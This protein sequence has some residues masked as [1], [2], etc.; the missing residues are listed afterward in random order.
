MKELCIYYDEC[1]KKELSSCCTSYMRNTDICGAC[2]E[3]ADDGCEGCDEYQ[4]EDDLI[5]KEADNKNKSE[6]DEN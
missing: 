6:R 4:T 3:H 5:E 2:G 1:D